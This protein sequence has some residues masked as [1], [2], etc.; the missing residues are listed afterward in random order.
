MVTSSQTATESRLVWRQ[1]NFVDHAGKQ[2]TCI[3]WLFEDP[4]DPSEPSG[5]SFSFQIYSTLPLDGNLSKLVQYI[6]SGIV[7]DGFFPSWEIYAQQPD[8]FSSVEHQRREIA[9]RKETSQTPTAASGSPSL[10]LIP[11]VAMDPYDP[12]RQ[13]FLIVITSD[14][15]RGGSALHKQVDPTGPLWVFFDRKFPHKASVDTIS[16]LENDPDQAQQLLGI[17]IEEIRDLT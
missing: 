6:G 4:R 8:V 9:L 13:G 3:R 17:S 10:P 5:R 14:S 2:A 16:G 7:R 15:Y 1:H 12:R 11:K